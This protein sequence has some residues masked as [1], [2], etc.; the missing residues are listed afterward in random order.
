[1]VTVFHNGNIPASIMWSNC[2]EMDYM[3]P[4]G[5]R[6][7]ARH[8]GIRRFR[9]KNVYT[10]TYLKGDFDTIFDSK[11]IIEPYYGKLSWEE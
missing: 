4:S 3:T 7:I 2:I 1:M 9:V 8:A 6:T 11:L 5:I 10:N